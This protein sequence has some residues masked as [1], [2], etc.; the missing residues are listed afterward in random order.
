LLPPECEK[1]GDERTGHPTE[2]S[3]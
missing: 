1:D 2:R 3:L